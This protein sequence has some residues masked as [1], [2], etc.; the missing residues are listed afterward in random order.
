[1]RS[2]FYGQLKTGCRTSHLT[3]FYTHLYIR[4]LASGV[5]TYVIVERQTADLV[6]EGF[7]LFRVPFSLLLFTLYVL[8][9][10]RPTETTHASVLQSL[11]YMCVS[12]LQVNI[13]TY[14]NYVC[15][16]PANLITRNRHIIIIYPKHSMHLTTDCSKD[17]RGYSC[18]F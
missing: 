11:I 4:Q 15:V 12:V 16:S 1:M 18:M 5:S 17:E 10:G 9:Q 14:S 8:Q 2:T 7:Q 3:K 6:G 13:I